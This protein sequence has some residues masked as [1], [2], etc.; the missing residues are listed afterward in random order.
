MRALGLIAMVG[1]RSAALVTDGSLGSAGSGDAPQPVFDAPIDRGID[2]PC[3]VQIG[4]T[5]AGTQW[6]TDFSVDPTTLD[7]NCDGLADFHM[8]QNEALP[9]TLSAGVWAETSSFQAPAQQLDTHPAEPFL[10]RTLVH[11]R[12]RNVEVGMGAR[13][14]ALLWV[15]VGD[16]GTHFGSVFVEMRLTGGA[17]TQ[18]ITLFTLSTMM[19]QSFEVVLDPIPGFD[20]GFHDV[21]LDID[22]PSRKVT[23]TVDG[24]NR[25]DYFFISNSV[26]G[27]TVNQTA[28]LTADGSSAEF[29]SFSVESCP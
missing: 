11:A 12:M 4:P 28:M 21:D 27:Q 16:D 5:C 26:G 19:D 17:M 24:V 6:S 1:C 10:T 20:T 25:G 23:F 29:D 9:G 18:N 3:V 15:D 22:P 14:G 7:T 2:A 8:R 13:H